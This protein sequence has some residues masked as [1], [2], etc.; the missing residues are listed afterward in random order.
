MPEASATSEAAGGFLALVRELDGHVPK[1]FVCIDPSGRIRAA[2]LPQSRGARRRCIEG[3]HVETLLAK[4]SA[5]FEAL[6]SELSWEG[7]ARVSLALGDEDAGRG[8][9]PAPRDAYLVLV[10]RNGGRGRCSVD[11]TEELEQCLQAMAHDLRNPL[12]A[13]QGF[14][15]LLEREFGARL[16]ARGRGYLEQLRAGVARM[17]ALLEDL[18]AAARRRRA[19]AP[20]PHLAALPLLRQ[21]VADLKAQ[22]EERNIRVA[23]PPDPPSLRAEPTLLYQVALNLISNAIQHMGRVDAPQIRVTLD[24]EPGGVTLCVRDNGTGV[25]VGDAER[26]FDPFFRGENGGARGKGLG[27]SIVRRIMDAHG[28]RVDLDV[29]GGQGASFRAFFPDSP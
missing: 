6:L 17:E 13:V 22:L 29:A 21:V 14:A 15:N 8:R 9:T 24:R 23:L 18:L 7:L 3:E 11:E 10:G 28:G 2:A 12:F 26:I 4:P 5:P 19:V 27:L 16:E 1:P 25:P 20:S